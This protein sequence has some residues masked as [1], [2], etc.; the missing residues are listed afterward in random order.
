MS[1]RQIPYVDL[2]S[3][4]SGVTGSLN[5]GIVKYPD[6]KT[7]KFVVDCGLFQEEECEKYNRTFPFNA[8][9]IDFCLVTHNHADHIGRLPLLSKKGFNGKIYLTK[10]TSEFIGDALTDSCKVIKNDAKKNHIHPLYSEDDKDRAISQICAC[11]YETPI[12]VDN[13]IKVTFFTNGHLVGAALILVQIS[14][15]G[16]DDINLLF[17][18]DY[19]NKNMFFDVPSLPEWVCDLP[20]TIVQ[21]STYGTMDSSEIT[22]CFEKNI[23]ECMYYNGTAVCTAFSLGRAQ[24]VLY[25]LKNMQDTGKLDPQIP[26]YFDGKLAQIYTRKYLRSDCLNIKPKMRNFMPQNTIWVD[27]SVRPRV[28][29]SPDK[30]IIVSSSGNGSYGPARQYI[31]NYISRRNALIQFTGYV[32][33]GS[34]GRRIKDAPHNEVVDVGSVMKVKKAKVEYTTEFSAHAKADEMIAFLSQFRNLKLVLVNHGNPD[35]KE[36]FAK[37]IVKE[38]EPKDVGILGREYFFRINQYGLV[39]TISTKFD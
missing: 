1:K 23:Y 28:V 15:V 10:G 35:V 36:K 4:Q 39:R 29:S 25:I 7:T 31:L 18:G 5:L 33:E 34:L 38:L 9:D 19:N 32:T 20:L 8:S 27:K 24:E 13:R 26:I 11:E 3:V 16:F 2:M 21:E 22:Y 6:G 30:K 17:T 12:Y 37:R 14:Y